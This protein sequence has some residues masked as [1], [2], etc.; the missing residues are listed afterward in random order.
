MRLLSEWTAILT[1]ILTLLT[2]LER[3]WGMLSR[4]L[5]RLGAMLKRRRGRR[6]NQDGQTL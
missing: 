1:A 4:L 6:S 3:T 5:N 2:L